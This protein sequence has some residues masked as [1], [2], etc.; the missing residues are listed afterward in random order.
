MTTQWQHWIDKAFLAGWRVRWCAAVEGFVID[1][2]ARPRHPSVSLGHYSD[3][4]AAWRGAAN[5]ERVSQS[6]SRVSQSPRL[7]DC[8]DLIHTALS[9]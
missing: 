2:P 1:S 6:P 7:Q 3:E 5:L 9:G 4:R 8:M